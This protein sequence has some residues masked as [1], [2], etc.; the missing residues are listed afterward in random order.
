MSRQSN[1]S[2]TS[3]DIT[4]TTGQDW[5]VSQRRVRLLNKRPKP[6]CIPVLDFKISLDV[7]VI[8]YDSSLYVKLSE[9]VGDKVQCAE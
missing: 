2:G 5:R 4:G 3:L 9:Q 1:Q 8:Q 7:G 6:E